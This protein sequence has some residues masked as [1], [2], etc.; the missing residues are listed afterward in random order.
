MTQIRSQ[1][2]LSAT[3][4]ER[5]K[6]GVIG[7]GTMGFNH[8][9]ILN[10]L[11]LDV[12][13][14]GIADTDEKRCKQVADNFQTQAF[15]DH[16]ELLS[17]QLDG[18]VIA[19]P[20]KFHKRVALDAFKAGVGVLVEKPI[21][22]TEQE[23]DEIISAAETAQKPLLIGHVERFN[24]AIDTLKSRL[25][26]ENVISI[27]ITRVGP[28]P[29]GIGDVGVVLD[30]GVHDIDLI[31]YLAGA[32]IRDV[33]AL[34]RSA[35]NKLEDTALLQFKT[36]NGILASIN[37]NW[38][39]P[40]KMREVHVATSGKFVKTDLIGQSVEENSH[41]DV[42]GAYTVQPVPVPRAEPLQR[43]ILHFADCLR[44]Q[45]Q[46]LVSGEAGRRA[47]RVALMCLEGQEV[48]RL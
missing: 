34:T 25:L 13:L 33:Y 28:F 29:Q 44:G 48:G 41:Y 8:V 12:E 27:A 24:P 36:E 2:Q 7:V 18:V 15:F 21:A 42:R 10:S 45:A 30:L 11:P 26:D 23:A 31:E 37:T 4:H 47:I 17:Q 19:V 39:T 22:S 46:P 40:F 38:I 16:T 14:V 35:D 6:I 43:E 32:P 3:P 5:V 1:S 9:R 20:T